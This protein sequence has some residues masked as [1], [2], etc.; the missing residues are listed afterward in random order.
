MRVGVVGDPERQRSG[1][2]RNI[3]YSDATM[4]NLFSTTFP[5]PIKINYQV[6]FWTKRKSEMNQWIVQFH[7]DFLLQTKYLKIEVDEFF[8]NKWVCLLN[9]G[10]LTDNS[11]L[12][13]GEDRPLV[14]YT[15]QLIAETWI[16]PRPEEVRR[17][18]AIQQVTLEVYDQ[19]DNLLASLEAP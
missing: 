17:D 14:R 15:A 5:I 12:E 1:R 2:L 9:D 19:Y 6:D 16:F 3:A 10:E 13:T 8:R 7:T 11:D 18:P 4:T